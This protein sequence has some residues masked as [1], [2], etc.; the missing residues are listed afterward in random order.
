M[1]RC[2]MSHELINENVNIF[3][4]PSVDEEHKGNAGNQ[5]TIG[6]LH[7][8]AMKLIF[9]LV[10]HGIASNINE[11]DYNSLVAIYRTSIYAL[12]KEHLDRFNGIL[13]NM[14]FTTDTLIRLIGDELA[15]R[16][17]NDYFTLKILEKLHEQ[18]VPVEI[19]LSNHGIEFIEACE[20]QKDFKPPMLKFG[21]ADSME[22]LQVLVDK[23]IVTRQEILEIA[24]K[25]YKPT[26]RAISYSLSEDEKEIT[27]YS[28][29][30]I[31][32]NTIQSLAQ[33][34]EVDYKDATVEKLAKTIYNINVQFQKHARNNTL[35]SLYSNEIM[36]DA[37]SGFADLS[38]APVESIMWNRSYNTINTGG[39]FAHR[40]RKGD[41][42]IAGEQFTEAAVIE[43]RKPAI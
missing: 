24:D 7:G 42:A 3:K 30:G 1:K 34:L 13:S 6:D 41:L 25:S 19:L 14:T 40:A 16:G 32:L 4:F 9:M 17:S 8:N 36:F 33:K 43:S 20:I 29:A 21:H 28:H 26:L 23:K 12:N 18:E 39:F 10:K 37:Y 15:D 31:G 2:F 38:N 27:I 22:N 5:I 35:H 11:D